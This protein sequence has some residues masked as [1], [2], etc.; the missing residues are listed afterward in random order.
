LPE[1]PKKKP[2]MEDQDDG[3]KDPDGFYQRANVVNIIFTGDPS[4]SK[5]A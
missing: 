2:D 4:F 3:K 1:V 5:R